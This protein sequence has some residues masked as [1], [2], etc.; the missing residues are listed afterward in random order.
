MHT[1]DP[2]NPT[3]LRRVHAVFSSAKFRDFPKPLVV[4]GVFSKAG[5]DITQ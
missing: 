5:K 3:V 4:S 1:E 2:H